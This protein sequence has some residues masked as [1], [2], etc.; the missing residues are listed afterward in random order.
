MLNK[1]N[2]RTIEKVYGDTVDWPGKR[3]ELFGAWV[4]YAGES[5]LGIRCR[6]PK[7]LP[8]P[9]PKSGPID[10]SIPF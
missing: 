5:A 2:W 6:I 9:A 7:P 10:D 3:V 4:E 1:T 8:S